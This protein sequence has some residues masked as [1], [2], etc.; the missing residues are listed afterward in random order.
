MDDGHILLR[1]VVLKELCV[2]LAV[3]VN[4]ECSTLEFLPHDPAVFDIYNNVVRSLATGNGCATKGIVKE[5]VLKMMGVPG[6]A[7]PY[8]D[9]TTLMVIQHLLRHVANIVVFEAPNVMQPEMHVVEHGNPDLYK[10]RLLQQDRTGKNVHYHVI[11]PFNK[12]YRGLSKL[13]QQKEMCRKLRQFGN[14]DGKLEVKESLHLESLGFPRER[15]VFVRPNC[16]F[17]RGDPITYYEIPTD[18][19]FVYAGKDNIPPGPVPYLYRLGHEYCDNINEANNF[20]RTANEKGEYMPVGERG[21]WM[22]LGCLVNSGE[23]VKDKSNN[24]SMKDVDVIGLVHPSLLTPEA[25]SQKD[26]KTYKVQSS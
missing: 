26:V 14:C 7:A 10:L 13:V 9:A 5:Y 11:L 24:C 3:D 23:S 22:G 25:Y 8:G 16:S 12:N 19:A 4:D 20:E 15:G 1:D 18:A 17:Q 2:I 21:L 6:I